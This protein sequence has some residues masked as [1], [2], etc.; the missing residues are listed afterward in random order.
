MSQDERVLCA[1]TDAVWPSGEAGGVS[2]R[3]LDSLSDLDQQFQCYFKPRS[4]VEHD[5]AWQHFC[6]Y[7]V[8]KCGRLV[9]VYRRP[10]KAGESRLSGRVSVGVGGHINIEDSD[11]HGVVSQTIWNGILREL[12]EETSLSSVQS[13]PVFGGPTWMI[14]DVTNDVGRV[15]TGIVQIIEVD[16]QRPQYAVL[17]CETDWT[18]PQQLFRHPDLESWS[19]IVL[20]YIIGL[21]H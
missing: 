5:P 13:P 7:V 6:S 9:Q 16:E 18:T 8:F 17:D 21:N 2:V 11:P 10:V 1:E 4:D 19:R 12:D 15:H 20:Q 14:R 3:R